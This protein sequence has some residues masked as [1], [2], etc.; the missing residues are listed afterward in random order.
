MSILND[1]DDS[2][3]LDDS[4]INLLNT[5]RSNNW[6]VDDYNNYIAQQAV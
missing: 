5:M 4:E 2:A 1:R 6:S 3:D